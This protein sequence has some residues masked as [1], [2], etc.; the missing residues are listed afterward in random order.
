MSQ[1]THLT[2][3]DQVEYHLMN[4]WKV[5]KAPNYLKNIQITMP[6]RQSSCC[7]NLE[8]NHCTPSGVLKRERL[9]LLSS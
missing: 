8:I 3:C 5:W 7:T 4:F 2:V 9:S 6:D 1:P